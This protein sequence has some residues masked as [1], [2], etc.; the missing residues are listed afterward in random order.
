VGK[1]FLLLN[2]SLIP[3]L[4]ASSIYWTSSSAAPLS[5]GLDSVSSINESGTAVGYSAGQAAEASISSPGVSLLGVSAPYSMAVAIN[6][7]G[8]IAGTYETQS[9]YL[10]GFFWSSSSGMVPLGTLGGDL[11]LVAA[12]DNAGQI[13]G[14]SLDSK[15]N[16][17][18]FLWSPGTGIQAIGTSS[19]EMATGIDDSGQIAYL[20]DPAP[21]AMTY[22]AV[23]GTSSLSLLNFGGQGSTISAMNDSGWMIGETSGGDGFLWTPQGAVNFGT[24]FLPTAINDSGEIAGTYQG[25]PAVW[26]ESGGFQFLNL[27]GYNG[28]VVTALND[29]GVIV[30]DSAPVPEPSAILLCLAGILLLA[31]GWRRKAS[32]K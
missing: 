18:A 20:Q 19:S 12:I 7:S 26:T 1:W 31:A 6:N 13:V 24:S 25:R 28:V 2:L 17:S 3:S 10:Y 30:A 11:S 29:N 14:E 16:L 15:G 22:G 21:Y 8:Q 23:G 27:G 32:A 4:P 5:L 9:G